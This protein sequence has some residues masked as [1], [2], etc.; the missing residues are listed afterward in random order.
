MAVNDHGFSR[1][2]CCFEFLDFSFAISCLK[3]C[4]KK[5]CIFWSFGCLGFVRV[6][7]KNVRA[8]ACFR[9]FYSC[10]SERS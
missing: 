6:R 2:E 1:F 4:L 9:S 7:L 5:V 10:S 8:N 3:V